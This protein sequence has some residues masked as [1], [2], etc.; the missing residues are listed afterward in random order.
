MFDHRRA[1]SLPDL[2]R[3]RVH[4]GVRFD[5]RHECECRIHLRRARPVHADV[6][7]EPQ[8]VLLARDVKLVADAMRPLARRLAAALDA[9]PE[10]EQ[11]HVLGQLLTRRGVVDPRL[12][13][14]R[15]D[16]TVRR[17]QVP[18]EQGG[19]VE[20]QR[21]YGP[22]DELL[23]AALAVEPEL[24]EPRSDRIAFTVGQLFGRRKVEVA[25][26]ALRDAARGDPE[27][28][29]CLCHGREI[30]LVRA[31]VVDRLPGATQPSPIM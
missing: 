17:P 10:Q 14:V 30:R 24:V 29:S 2:D 11:P 5:L 21:K 25:P 20:R 7:Q 22:R 12:G 23:V 27:V 4:I 28:T 18:Q 31:R 16:A 3:D 15:E 19:L 13:R 26:G 9:E 8:L 1:H 6:L